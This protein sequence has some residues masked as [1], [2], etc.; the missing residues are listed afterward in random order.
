[1]KYKYYVYQQSGG[2]TTEVGFTWADVPE[3]SK[4]IDGGPVP[5]RPITLEVFNPE[6]RLPDIA[7]GLSGQPHFFSERAA[8]I[9]RQFSPE[10]ESLY[11]PALACPQQEKHKGKIDPIPYTGIW[12]LIELDAVDE[13]KSIFI[14]IQRGPDAR[15]SPGKWFYKDIEVLA[16]KEDV[17]QGRHHFRLAGY[18]DKFFISHELAVALKKLPRSNIKIAPIE[19]FFRISAYNLKKDPLEPR[20]VTQMFMTSRVGG[21]EGFYK[22]YCNVRRR[23]IGDP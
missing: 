7:C 20:N 12:P 23:N 18:D 5:S 22:Q 2:L 21:W 3:F 13:S 8:D 9:F 10:S 15:E 11:M 17:V 19:K 14:A 4:W 1:M 16:L 6:A